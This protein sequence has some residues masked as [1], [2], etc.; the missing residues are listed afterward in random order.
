MD[1][2]FISFKIESGM[3]YVGGGSNL[4]QPSFKL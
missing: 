4:V 1:G 2:F 3:Y